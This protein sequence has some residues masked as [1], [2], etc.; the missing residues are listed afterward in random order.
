MFHKSYF[1]SKL[2]SLQRHFVINERKGV[3][4]ERKKKM[5]IV[6]FLHLYK[7]LNFYA[8][9]KRNKKQSFIMAFSNSHNKFFLIASYNYHVNWC[10]QNHYYFKNYQYLAYTIVNLCIVLF[11]PL[12][13]H[14]YLFDKLVNKKLIWLLV[15][16]VAIQL[17][18]SMLLNA[19]MDTFFL[20]NYNVPWLMWAE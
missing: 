2:Q 20:K 4:Y 17:Y 19:L 6:K 9:V 11:F 14:F 10:Q 5:C 12:I 16:V 8:P 3:F 18:T 1:L 7:R 13:N 15:L